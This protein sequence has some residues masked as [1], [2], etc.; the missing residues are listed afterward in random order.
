[1]NH[2][3]VIAAS[4]C[5]SAAM[6][7]GKH[8]PLV[9]V[10]AGS[11]TAPA[12]STMPTPTTVSTGVPS[13][14]S[15][16]SPTISGPMLSASL[17]VALVGP[18]PQRV[19]AGQRDVTAL[20]LALINT[21]A[22]PVELERLVVRAEGRLDDPSGVSTARLALDLDGDLRYDRFADRTLSSAGFGL[23][24]GDLDFPGAGLT[25]APGDT[26]V[27][28]IALDFTGAGVV[29]DDIR[30]VADAGALRV[31][32]PTQHT[33]S[34][35]PPPLAGPVLKLGHWVEP[36]LAVDVP[37]EGLR[38]RAARDAQG[39]THLAVFQNHNFNSEV[40]YS[41]Y[42]GRTFSNVDNISRTP[43]TAW[44]QDIAVDSR[45]LPTIVWEQWDGGPGDVAIR[46]S[47]FDPVAFQWTPSQTVS[48]TP[49]DTALDPRATM[50]PSAS[51]DTLHVAF[52]QWAGA[53]EPHVLHR[54]RDAQGRWSNVADV[55][56]AT[57][58]ETAQDPTLAVDSQQRLALAWV[59]NGP[60]FSEIRLR[61]H[62]AQGWSPAE[63]VA[64]AQAFAERPELIAVGDTL[65]L[66]YLD[67]GHVFYT[68]R[69][70]GQTWSAPVNVSQNLAHQ[71]THPTLVAFQNDLHVAW[72]E[73][74]GALK[75]ARSQGGG[76]SAPET[77]TRGPEARQLPVFVVED[78]RLRLLWQDRSLGR[79][80]IFTT[81]IDASHFEAPRQVAQPGGDPSSIHAAAGLMGELP[82]VYEVHA[83]G[84]AEVFYTHEDRPG[85]D[86]NTAENVSRS[87]RG[88]YKPTV[89]AAG[90]EAWVAW[91]EDTP[92]G[93]AIRAARRSAVGWSSPATISS[94]LQ[95]YS[96]RL[97][98]DP[99]GRAAL[100]WTALTPN[101]DY[102]L[103]LRIFDGA[104]WGPTED[105]A[106]DAS[107][108]SWSPDLARAPTGDTWAVIWEDEAQVGRTLRYALRE[109]GTT[110][111][112]AVA[113]SNS[114]QRAPKLTFHHDD[115]VATWVEDGRVLVAVRPQ[116]ALDF[117][118]P[119]TLSQG[120][121]WAPDVA[122]SGET[123][124]V[125]WEQWTG[126]DARIVQAVLTP[127]GWSN[128]TPI[129]QARG[130]GQHAT[131]V[132]GV[133]GGIRT[134][135]TES[136]RVLE[137]TRRTR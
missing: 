65:H 24:D 3:I 21:G 63:R 45:N 137:R 92:Q 88:S 105:L 31:T 134:L 36:H 53:V 114:Q 26:A 27:A 119:T 113:S 51:G 110:T 76:F 22:E 69:A 47:G 1:M 12:S 126:N 94:D 117:D 87:A 91:E 125:S 78:D 100:V 127:Q 25:V 68:Q 82:V 71:A 9:Q 81:W 104:Q 115:L 29:N 52:E 70:P 84:N 132:G 83:G 55:S 58:G 61:H 20:A 54:S 96:P 5:L 75:T 46:V 74:T 35:W 120:G 136:G 40:H 79:Q 16:A 42:D 118:T 90:T 109:N 95:A 60:G 103:R 86:F 99:D 10:S 28:L 89:T 15:V 57:A 13:S 121:S 66:V 18:G 33:V 124:T 17:E 37:G 2:R 38:P 122:V 77:L 32:T 8:R 128:A 106:P 133:S 23:P 102:D 11:A 7:C 85:A 14:T 123:L 131:S 34:R 135:W 72:V 50:V 112:A 41:L 108:H 93:F 64:S 98:G 49:G 30:L 111:V 6:G 19:D 67:Q 107:T 73:G 62:T 43:A 97:A 4:L 56:S 80:R 39:R 130:P 59:H 101:G 48:Y 129:D 116:G 44:N